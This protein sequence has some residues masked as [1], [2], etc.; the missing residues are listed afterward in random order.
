MPTILFIIIV[1]AISSI[2][3]KVKLKASQQTNKSNHSMRQVAI[4]APRVHI[5][6]PVAKSM[7]EMETV[8]EGKPLASKQRY[9]E[10]D[11]SQSEK[12]E[13]SEKTAIS[14]TRLTNSE[15]SVS[16]MMTNREVADA[17]RHTSYRL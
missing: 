2:A 11:S 7:V 6:F 3:I 10:D 17:L 13:K 9:Q 16:R 14:A 4:Q 5:D 8:P 1:I 15:S 12:S